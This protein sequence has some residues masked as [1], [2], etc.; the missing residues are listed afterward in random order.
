MPIYCTYFNC[1]HS[2]GRKTSSEV[3]GVFSNPS[4]LS[5][6]RKR[7]MNLRR[8]FRVWAPVSGATSQPTIIP[9]TNM[10]NVHIRIFLNNRF[11]TCA[12]LKDGHRC[13]GMDGKSY[14]YYFI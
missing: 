11:K 1:Y 12:A 13:I 9:A 5:S 7:L 6:P 4:S 3:M 8:L 10:V 2:P 14:L